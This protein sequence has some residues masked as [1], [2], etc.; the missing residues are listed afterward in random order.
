MRHHGGGKKCNLS[1]PLLGLVLTRVYGGKRHKYIQID[2]SL[3]DDAGNPKHKEERE[4]EGKIGE[5]GDLETWLQL[6]SIFWSDVA[7]GRSWQCDAS[8]SGSVTGPVTGSNL[9]AG[10]PMFI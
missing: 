8:S 6:G 1:R 3:S 10:T 7:H 5:E 9:L 2:R 4:K